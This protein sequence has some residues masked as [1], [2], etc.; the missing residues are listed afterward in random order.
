MANGQTTDEIVQVTR[1]ARISASNILWDAFN[2]WKEQHGYTT[3][4]EGIRAAMV[5]VTNFKPECQEKSCL[6]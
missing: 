3:L 4:A 1:D 6:S 5:E 2:E